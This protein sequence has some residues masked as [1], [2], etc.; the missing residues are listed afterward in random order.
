MAMAGSWMLTVGLAILIQFS[1]FSGAHGVVATSRAPRV[2]GATVLLDNDQCRKQVPKAQGLEDGCQC[3]VPAESSRNIWDLKSPSS[4]PPHGVELRQ[5][6][7]KGVGL[8]ATASFSQGEE[9]GWAYTHTLPCEDFKASTSLGSVNIYCDTHFFPLRCG[10]KGPGKNFGVFPEWLD[11]LNHADE[12]K[13]SAYF[14]SS[15]FIVGSDGQVLKQR[16]KLIA[17]RQIAPDEE[18]TYDYCYGFQEFRDNRKAVEALRG[19]RFGFS[20]ETNG[21]ALVTQAAAMG[22]G[23]K[24]ARCLLAH[25]HQANHTS[26]I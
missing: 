2:R 19:L 12:G 21:T 15:D 6:G 11:L 4:T 18:L 24:S 20:Q 1:C 22:R 9:I 5:A 25:S 23:P 7:S 8:F 14:G 3:L 26:A 17:A 10:S 16:W 13:S